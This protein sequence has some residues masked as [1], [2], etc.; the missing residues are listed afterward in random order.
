MW[1]VYLNDGVCENGLVIKI[2]M[3][4]INISHSIMFHRLSCTI[5]TSDQKY[6]A[7]GSLDSL[8]Y[9]WKRSNLS[10]ELEK[11]NSIPSEENENFIEW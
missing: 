4:Y 9:L 2:P 8:I 1:P 3:S 10:P 7:A 6:V 11:N 5:L